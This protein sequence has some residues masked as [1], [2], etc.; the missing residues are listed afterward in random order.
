MEEFNKRG[1]SEVIEILNH[2]DKEIVKKIPQ[3]FINFLFDN[4]DDNYKPNIN[5]YDVDW[6]NHLQEDT[7]AILA[8]IYRDYILSDDEREE[9]LK[10]EQE[11]KLK[12]EK[13]LQEKYNPDNLFKKKS[14]EKETQISNKQLIEVKKTSWFRRILNKIFDFFGGK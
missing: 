7:Q 14:D 8:L 6:K 11:D 5:F 12:Q 2:T 10:T 13:K 4:S 1:I 9:L 3:N